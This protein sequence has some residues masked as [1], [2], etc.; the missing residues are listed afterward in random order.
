MEAHA[1]VV[2][3]GHP[4]VRGTHPTTFEIT[5]EGH[6]TEAG[7][8]IIGVAAECGAAG[9][10]PEFR[11]V[12]CHDRA[13]LLTRLSL[14]DLRV[15]VHSRGSAALTLTHPTDMVWRRSRYVDGRTVGIL[16]DRTAATL[17]RDLICLLRTGE[18]LV[19]EMTASLSDEK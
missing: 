5:T 12:L 19:V 7:D 18:T 14:C 11:R 16:S 15:E 8:C 6:L 17:P 9:L 2:C 3:R 1:T 10:P 13:V 4:R